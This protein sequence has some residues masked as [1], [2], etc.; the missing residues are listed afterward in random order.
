M[1]DR[2]VKRSVQGHVS[3]MG[4]VWCVKSLRKTCDRLQFLV[5][6]A[7]DGNDDKWKQEDIRGSRA[8]TT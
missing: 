3:S 5:R 7:I 6:G 1:N 2:K 4:S 8:A